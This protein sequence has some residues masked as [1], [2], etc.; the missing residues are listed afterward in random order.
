MNVEKLRANGWIPRLTGV[1]SDL[2][3]ELT[4]LAIS[5][6]QRLVLELEEILDTK[7]YKFP[8]EEER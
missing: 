6:H 3:E 4:L 5:R 2:A 8:F 7:D 1:P